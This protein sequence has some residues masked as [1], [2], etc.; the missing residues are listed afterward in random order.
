[1][2]KSSF[3][4][5]SGVST[6]AEDRRSQSTGGGGS[7]GQFDKDL[8]DL[9]DPEENVEVQWADEEDNADDESFIDRMAKKSFAHFT[10]LIQR[11]SVCSHPYV[12]VMLNRTLAHPM[13]NCIILR[14]F[15][16]LYVCLHML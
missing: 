1:M 7:L 13:W 11:R 14:I 9:D 10:A 5:R 4:R 3:N 12:A 16:L 15:L 6:S 8:D 2:R